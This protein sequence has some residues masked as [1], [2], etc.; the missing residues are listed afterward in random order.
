MQQKLVGKRARY[1]AMGARRSRSSDD[2]IVTTKED[3]S[4]EQFESCSCCCSQCSQCSADGDSQSVAAAIDVDEQEML[5]SCSDCS[6]CDDRKNRA[7]KSK[8]KDQEEDVSDTSSE[9]L[10]AYEEFCKDLAEEKAKDRKSSPDKTKKKSAGYYFD[11]DFKL[12]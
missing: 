11:D 3:S 9:N 2:E 7:V 10:D 5:S 4:A 12:S 1:L 6:L 8:V